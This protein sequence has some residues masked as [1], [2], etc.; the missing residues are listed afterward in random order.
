MQMESHVFV[1]NICG[2]EVMHI[3]LYTAICVYKISAPTDSFRDHEAADLICKLWQ[4]D[5]TLAFYLGLHQV[6][7]SKVYRYRDVGGL[8]LVKGE[9]ST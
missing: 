7:L 4:C 9:K 3:T 8:N 2:D 6:K 1:W 5:P